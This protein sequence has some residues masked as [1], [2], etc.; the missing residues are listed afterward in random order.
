MAVLEKYLGGFTGSYT[1]VSVNDTSIR[2]IRLIY[3]QTPL[4]GSFPNLHSFVM[5]SKFLP[6]CVHHDDRVQDLT[7]HIIGLVSSS[8]VTILLCDYFFCLE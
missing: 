3:L 8:P 4:C 7:T 2:R 1:L 6:C 5:L